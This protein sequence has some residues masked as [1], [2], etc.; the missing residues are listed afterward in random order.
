MRWLGI[1][2]VPLVVLL[3]QSPALAPFHDDLFARPE[4]LTL[5]VG[6][7]VISLVVVVILIGILTGFLMR[8]F[9]RAGSRATFLAVVSVAAMILVGDYVFALVFGT[10]QARGIVQLAFLTVLNFLVLADLLMWS[11][12]WLFSR[13]V[14]WSEALR[15]LI[16]PALLPTIYAALR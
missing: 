16:I 14:N 9:S 4:G 12:P 11:A 5:L 2:F 10:R 7:V 3:A 8:A 6:R 1:V 15:I 13:R